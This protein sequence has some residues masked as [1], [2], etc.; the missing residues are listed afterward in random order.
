VV[1]ALGAG[2]ASDDLLRVDELSPAI[3]ASAM[4]PEPT[5][6]IVRFDREA[7]RPSMARA[8]QPFPAPLRRPGR[9]I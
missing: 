6:A 2:M 4:T 5:V 9:P 8:D 7:I 3:I 1:A